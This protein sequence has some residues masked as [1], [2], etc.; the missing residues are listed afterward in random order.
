[1]TASRTKKIERTQAVAAARERKGEFEVTSFGRQRARKPVA[2]IST[3]LL[4]LSW[5][6]LYIYHRVRR[7]PA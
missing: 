3:L 5:P 4:L 1:M 2:A 7:R 6:V